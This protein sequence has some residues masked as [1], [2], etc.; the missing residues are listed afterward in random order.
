MSMSSPQTLDDAP[1]DIGDMFTLGGL[2]IYT[3]VYKIYAPQQ[4][5]LIVPNDQKS[6]AG[7][8]GSHLYS[9]NDLI[10]GQNYRRHGTYKGRKKYFTQEEQMQHFI[11]LK[12]YRNMLLEVNNGHIKT[13]DLKEL[14]DS[15]KAFEDSI[16]V[17]IKMYVAFESI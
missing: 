7:W 8:I 11:S 14:L 1:L 13:K 6:T 10:L 15:I 12:R 16:P 5:F 9:S 17:E 2:I 4:G 3:C